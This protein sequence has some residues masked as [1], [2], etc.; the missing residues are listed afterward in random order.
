MRMRRVRI[1]ED[2]M[3]QTPRPGY[4][5][6]RQAT[7]LAQQSQG[8][9]AQTGFEQDIDICDQNRARHAPLECARHNTLHLARSPRG[10]KREQS[11]AQD[12]SER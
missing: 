3:R 2:I 12:R 8:V 4:N 11:F 7:R 6:W 9:K 10:H 5:K 1:G